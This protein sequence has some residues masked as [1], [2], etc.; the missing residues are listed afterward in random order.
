MMREVSWMVD[1]G[2]CSLGVGTALGLAGIEGV[3]F[4]DE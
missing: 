1:L 4:G 2:G 3:N